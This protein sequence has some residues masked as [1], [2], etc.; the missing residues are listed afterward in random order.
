MDQR[1]QRA[2]IRQARPARGASAEMFAGDLALAGV[3][4]VIRVG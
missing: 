4:F 3:K 2:L 1:L